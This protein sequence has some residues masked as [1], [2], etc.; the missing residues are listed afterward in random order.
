MLLLPSFHP[1]DWFSF[2]AGI[3]S[4]LLTVF[5]AI[6]TIPHEME[7]DVF[8]DISKILMLDRRDPDYQSDRE[9]RKRHFDDCWR[10]QII[11]D[12]AYLLSLEILR[13]P[14]REARD[15][16]TELGTQ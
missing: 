1:E 15:A 4:P 9:A 12:D 8:M 7:R 14:K 11:G 13:Y 3:T 16:L 10:K 2:L 5:C 6:L